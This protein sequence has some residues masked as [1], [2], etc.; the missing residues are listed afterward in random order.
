MPVSLRCSLRLRH[1]EHYSA[2]RRMST[3]A[4]PDFLVLPATVFPQVLRCAGSGTPATGDDSAPGSLPPRRQDRRAGQIGCEGA[5]GPRTGAGPIGMLT[6]R[7][8]ST[9]STNCLRAGR[10]TRHGSPPSSSRRGV[11][12]CATCTCVG[13]WLT[14][15]RRGPA[16]IDVPVIVV[17]GTEPRPAVRCDATARRMPALIEGV[18]LVPVDCGP[19]NIAWTHPD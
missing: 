6:S 8:L 3:P 12:R 13:T 9:T 18:R 14:D 16:Q 17:H 7:A 2:R 10:A 11:S 15:F 19:H 1:R 5:C 4:T